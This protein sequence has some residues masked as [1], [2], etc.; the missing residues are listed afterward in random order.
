MIDITDKRVFILLWGAIY[1]AAISVFG[2][3]FLTKTIPAVGWD[4]IIDNWALYSLIIL[5][6]HACFA[7]FVSMAVVCLMI[8]ELIKL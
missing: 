4:Y 2:W 7:L 1:L 6:G 5:G 8:G 3:I